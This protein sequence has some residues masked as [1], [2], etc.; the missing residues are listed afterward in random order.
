[1]FGSEQHNHQRDRFGVG[2]QFETVLA[3]SVGVG[4]RLVADRV[5]PTLPTALEFALVAGSQPVADELLGSGESGI[6]RDGAVAAGK[7][8][9]VPIGDADLW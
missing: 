9:V 4:V 6:N 5:E 7:P 2:G 8:P 1:L 3:G